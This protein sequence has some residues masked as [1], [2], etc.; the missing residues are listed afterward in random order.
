MGG[1]WAGS[2]RSKKKQ[3]KPGAQLLPTARD[4]V[5][6][7]GTGGRAGDL[8]TS[9][10]PR[11]PQDCHMYLPNPEPYMALM[12]PRPASRSDL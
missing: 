10:W 12:P 6:T 3:E 1:G 5:P 2:G 9:W 8:G 11:V 4:L 7:P